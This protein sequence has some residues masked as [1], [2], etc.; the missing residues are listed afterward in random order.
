MWLATL[1]NFACP[2]FILLLYFSVIRLPDPLS[3][4]TLGCFADVAIYHANPHN[5]SHPTHN[6]SGSA[7]AEP[8]ISGLAA[9]FALLQRTLLAQIL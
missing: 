5:S 4:A 8:S 7:P 6:K 3:I 2:L 1:M 9:P